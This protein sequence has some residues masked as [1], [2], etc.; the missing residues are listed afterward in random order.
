MAHAEP[1]VVVETSSWKAEQ[2]LTMINR[3]DLAPQTICEIGCGYG[4]ILTQLQAKMARDCMFVGYEIAPQALEFCN[5]RAN[6]RL[7]F[8]LKDITQVEDASFDLLLILDVIEHVEDYLGFLRNVR[9][10]ARY[11]IFHIPLEFSAIAALRRWPRSSWNNCGS[12]DNYCHGHIHYFMKET[13]LQSLQDTGYTILDFFYTQEFKRSSS[14]S[15]FRSS[16]RPYMF[17]LFRK[18]IFSI[19]NDDLAVRAFG[20][21]S[22]LVLTE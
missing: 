10:K 1:R 20:G 14:P 7:R 8:E 18:L 3:H 19:L 13:A 5:D 17:N 15:K 12:W 11:K 6:E 2:I 16:S 9:T 21:C 22:L 4:E